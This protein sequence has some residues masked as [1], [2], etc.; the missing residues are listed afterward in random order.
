ML[1]K[2]SKFALGVVLA[3]GSVCAFAQDDL[4]MRKYLSVDYNHIFRDNNRQSLDGNGGS[5]GFGLPLSKLWG[6]EASAFYN[7]F[8]KDS[9][10]LGDWDD[11]GAKLDGM[12]FYSRSRAFSPYFG[13]GVGVIHSSEHTSSQSSTDPFVDVGLGFFKYFGIGSQDFAVRADARYRW[14]DT[15][16]INGVG[17]LGEPVVKVGLVIP[18]GA[19]AVAVAP[20]VAAAAEAPAVQPKPTAPVVRLDSDG[21][22]VYDDQDNCPG[23]PAGTKVDEHGCPIEEKARVFEAVHFDFNKS[24]L[25]RQSEATLDNAAAVIKDMAKKS[26][27]KVEVGGHTDNVGTD[28]Y[29]QALSERRA[30]TV[31]KYLTDKGVQGKTI[32]TNAYGDTLPEKN[33]ATEEGR[34]YNRRVEVKATPQ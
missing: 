15:H 18:L 14:L 5:I 12:F 26:P 29:N 16:N 31:T 13:T 6:L 20:V 2:I 21:D 19:R 24:S 32:S 27:V 8:D 25:T 11:Y 28:G 9:T 30:Q 4:E 22:G 34:A 17:S 1:N 33:N 10:H 3:A 7:S 23:T